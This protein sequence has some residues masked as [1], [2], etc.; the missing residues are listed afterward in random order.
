MKLACQFLKYQGIPRTNFRLAEEPT[1]S[2]QQ[3]G[4]YGTQQRRNFICNS[5]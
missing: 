3:G 1:S 4:G 2:K 5:N